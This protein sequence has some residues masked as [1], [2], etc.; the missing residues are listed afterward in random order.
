MFGFGFVGGFFALVLVFVGFLVWGFLI[1]IN[2]SYIA[3]N[4]KHY[5]DQMGYVELGLKSL[6]EIQT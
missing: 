3:C 6:S 2:I 5:K 4:T 1:Y